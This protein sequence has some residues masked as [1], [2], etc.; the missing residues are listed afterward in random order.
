MRLRRA[1]FT[2]LA[3]AAFVA[4]VM[5][6]AAQAPTVA[7]STLEKDPANWPTYSGDHSSK[8]HSPLKQ[9]NKANVKALQA[10]WV[11]NMYFQRDLQTHPVVQNGIMY[12]SAYNRI[13]A[14]DATTGRVI[15]QYQRQ[16]LSTAPQR[17]TAV[18]DNK[19]YVTTTDK[20]L[21]ALDARNGAVVW[22]VPTGEGASLAG[23]APIIANGVLIVSGNR[24][25]FG[26][27]EKPGGFIQGYDAKTGKYLWTWSSL[28]KKDEA[29]YKTWGGAV[30]EGGPIWLSGSYDPALNLIY[31]GTGQPEPQWANEGRPGDNL[32][33]DSVIALDPNTGKMKWHFQFTPNDNHDWDAGQIPILVDAPWKG[34]D[35]KLMLWAN[36]NG[37]YYILD[38]ATG[39][40]LQ[41]T[42]FADKVNWALS[43]DSKGRPTPN[44]AASPTVA[45][46]EV[47]PSTAGATNWPAPT[48]DP[49]SKTFFLVVQDGCS[50]NFRDSA[51]SNAAGGY[52]E[53]PQNP[54]QLYT[55]ALDAFTGQKKWDYKQTTS[56]RYGPGTMSTAGGLLFTGE[57]NGSFTALDSATGKPLWSFNTGGS[58]VTSAMTYEVEGVQYIGL[59]SGSNIFSFAL[60]DAE[61]VKAMAST[62]T[63]AAMGGAQ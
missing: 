3:M 23:Q 44:P 13:D 41:A 34:K 61:A 33:T 10:K 38:R 7:E 5:P 21:V 4:G 1:L 54:W 30:P 37:Y 43:I 42:K 29:A 32:W 24:N 57:K 39:E 50:V 35:R 2:S 17:G 9:I 25:A 27:Q 53:S 47:C 56:I 12:V 63:T 46:A 60:P 59:T 20:H 16:P 6:A 31:Y 51:G 14:L 55:R 45:G 11:Y 36:R 48:Y 22:D 19:V 62:G 8:R 28:P 49:A 26:G 52:L 18:W 40:F 58:I 15:W